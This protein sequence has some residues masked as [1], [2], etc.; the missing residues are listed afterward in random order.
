MHVNSIPKSCCLLCCCLLSCLAVQMSCT[1]KVCAVETG[2]GHCC[3]GSNCQFQQD[4]FARHSLGRQSS[5]P[6]RAKRTVDGAEAGPASQAPAH[7][8]SSVCLCISGQQSVLYSAINKCLSRRAE[9]AACGA[10]AGPPLQTSAFH[11]CSLCLCQGRR[12]YTECVCRCKHTVAC[13]CHMTAK[14]LLKPCG[15]D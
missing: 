1:L 7:H 11:A 10:A 8:A 3:S 2:G 12:R 13:L 6:G 4:P 5:K 15:H 14:S 9:R